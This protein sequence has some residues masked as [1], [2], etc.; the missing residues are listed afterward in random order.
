MREII[1]RQMFDVAI[2]AAIGANVIAAGD[3]QGIAQERA[4]KML[5]RRY[6]PQAQAARKTKSWQ[7]THEADRLRSKCLRKRSSPSSK[8]KNDAFS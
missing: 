2:Q 3:G 8:S 6:H 4:G 5:R 1:S 7:E